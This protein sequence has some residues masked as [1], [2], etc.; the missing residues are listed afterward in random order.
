VRLQW[1]ATRKTGAADDAAAV[2]SFA[3]SLPPGSLL[4]HH[5]V[6]DLGQA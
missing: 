1:N 2:V 5:V 6:G 3:R 4:R